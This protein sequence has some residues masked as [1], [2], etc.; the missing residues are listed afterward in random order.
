M[1]LPEGQVAKEVSGGP[2][3]LE[4]MI[5]EC[6]SDGVSGYIEVRSSRDGRD[7][8]GQVVIRDG[9]P[10]LSS[11]MVGEEETPGEGSIRFVLEDSQSNGAR[12]VLHTAIDVDLMSL[13]FVKAKVP[14]E[15]YDFSKLYGNLEKLKEEEEQNAKKRALEEKRRTQLEE[16]LDSWVKGGYRVD[17]LEKMMDSADLDRLEKEFDRFDQ[18]VKTLAELDRQL[19]ELG[20]PDMEELVLSI[21]TKLNDPDKIDE[22]RKDL[23]E[24]KDQ[25]QLRG[26]QKEEFLKRIRGWKDEGYAVD[27]LEE[28][29]RSNPATAW[30]SFTATMDGITKLKEIEKKLGDIQADG[31]EPEIESIGSKLKVP[32]KAAEAEKELEVMV[33]VLETEKEKKSKLA[34]EIKGLAGDRYSTDPVDRLMDKRLS[35]VEEAAGIFK[36][37]VARLDDIRTRAEGERAPGL[38]KEFD[39]FISSVT[40][41]EKADDYEK[42][43]D[44]LIKTVQEASEKR[45]QLVG[46]VAA[47]RNEGYK[48]PSTEEM[49]EVPV[50]EL[51]NTVSSLEQGIQRINDLQE[52][53]QKA[54]AD[55]LDKEVA[56]VEPLMNQPMKLSE[57][58]EKI[59][60]ITQGLETNKQRMATIEEAIEKWKDEGYNMEALEY[61]IQGGVGKAWDTYE[62]TRDQIERITGSRKKLD[63][64]EK[65]GYEEDIESIK[66]MMEFPDNATQIEDITEKLLGRIGKDDGRREEIAREFNGWKDDGY[67]SKSFEEKFDSPLNELE[68][69][70]KFL[71]ETRERA[72]SLLAA[73]EEVDENDLGELK[74]DLD[75]LKGGL[76]DLDRLE[77]NNGLLDEFNK[78]LDAQLG[79]R[80]AAMD[81]V[82]A[83]KEEGYD[84]AFLNGL[85]EGDLERLGETILDT[86]EKVNRLKAMSE[87]LTQL[88]TI[89]R[90]KELKDL[91]GL[92]KRPEK[93]DDT[94]KAFDEFKSGCEKEMERVS[95]LEKK[96]QEWKESGYNLESLEDVFDLE[97]PEM[98]K[99]FTEFEEDLEKLLALQKKL[100]LAAPPGTVNQ[101]AAQEDEGSGKLAKKDEAPVEKEG[102]RMEGQVDG[103][104]IQVDGKE[105]P[106]GADTGSEKGKSPP[107]SEL[108]ST[109]SLN[110]QFTFDTF[111]VG[112]SNR[113]AHAASLAVAE[114]PSEAYNPLFVWGGVGLGK[115]HLLH[116]IGNHVAERHADLNV[117]YVTSEDFTNE[118]INCVRYDR[119]DDFRH[120][121]RKADILLIDDVQF[122][123]GKESTQEE[124][125]HTFNALYNSH[126]QIVVTSDRPPKDIDTLEERLRSRFEGGLITDIHPPS[127]ETKI[128]ILRRESKRQNMELPDE[129]THQIATK[130][131]SNIR[132]LH[133]VLNKAIARSNL[134]GE[135][136]TVPMVDEI[137]KDV[138][139]EGEKTAAKPKS[140]KRKA[141]Y[142][143]LE[144]RLSKLK[145][146]LNIDNSA[147]PGAPSKPFSKSPPQAQPAPAPDQAQPQA[148]VPDQSPPQSISQV[149]TPDQVPPQSPTQSPP[150]VQARSDARTPASE[151][152]PSQEGSDERSPVED[153]AKCGSCGNVIPSDST[154]CIHCG[155]TFGG[156]WYECPECGSMI[157]ADN[158]K[159]DNCGAEFELEDG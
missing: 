52:V 1:K 65:R 78:K 79:L 71:K 126:K 92:L 12:L 84:V 93:T 136:I 95:E 73:L 31:F 145:S 85:M 29:V 83:W 132:E 25:Q 103:K 5:K 130:I 98:E 128:I 66:Q 111:V 61:S 142:S 9:T 127:L 53:L 105:P 138:V 115:S 87:E 35:V 148:P 114:S 33:G 99:R 54:R 51:E 46:I 135:D 96:F 109:V 59:K 112:T 26:Q 154:E 120:K 155:A 97:L 104:V 131:K 43:L 122:I 34:Q 18:D 55:G 67:S 102:S 117:V 62:R 144:E 45:A 75:S 141:K 17:S 68:E 89:G 133:G 100:G 44:D 143:S 36:T 149:P 39:E 151:Q 134:T 119:L 77:E 22:I 90:E 158:L 113:F 139:D 13:Y 16:R 48:V 3:A 19:V 101:N 40:D 64:I 107:L 47:W 23:D 82:T 49:A 58:E 14:A 56:E 27:Q 70:F 11:H 159:C 15:S 41:V 21:E 80:Q 38:E 157:A 69:S 30:E 118:L 63:G 32:D 153:M 8:I 6:A 129:V 88:R 140:G 121:Y 106:A 81:K 156:E 74:A 116:A 72:D 20:S 147:V 57:L 28:Q 125:F 94:V 76:K 60:P 152:A 110:D 24:I 91:E 137:I 50:G 4:E 150:P 123:A 37:A 10:I 124:F 7:S 2:K 108:L 86:E 146:K 42:G